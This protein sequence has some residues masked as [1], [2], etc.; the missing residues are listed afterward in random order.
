MIL[1]PLR[2]GL[3]YIRGLKLQREPSPLQSE[4][5]FG[6]LGRGVAGGIDRLLAAI[7]HI[8]GP[9]QAGSAVAADRFD[10]LVLGRCV[11]DAAVALVAVGIAYLL[12]YRT[13][14]TIYRAQRRDRNAAAAEH[15]GDTDASG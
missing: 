8:E 5:P 9:H 6:S 1:R 3:T 11:F 15:P 10:C 7:A 13:D 2:R 14:V 4:P 12:I